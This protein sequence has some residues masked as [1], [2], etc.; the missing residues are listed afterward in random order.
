MGKS[1]FG[2]GAIRRKKISLKKKVFLVM[3]YNYGEEISVEFYCELFHIISSHDQK[4]N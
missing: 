3:W 2:W 4:N 1:N